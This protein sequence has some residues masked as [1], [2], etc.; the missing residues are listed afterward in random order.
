MLAISD[1]Y[2]NHETLSPPRHASKHGTASPFSRA[3]AECSEQRAGLPVPE[4]LVTTDDTT[5]SKPHPTAISRQRR[6]LGV[7][8]LACVVIEDPP[9]VS[10]PGRRPACP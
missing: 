3:E 1:A 2:Q 4:V 10:R 6:R 7:A 8:P 9:A 5:G